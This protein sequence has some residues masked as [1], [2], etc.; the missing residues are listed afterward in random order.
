MF[1]KIRTILFKVPKTIRLKAVH[2]FIMKILNRW[3][4]QQIVQNHLSDVEFK[5]LVEL[6]KNY[7]KG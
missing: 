2:Y 7:T 5:D 3:E 4:L 1:L 6:N